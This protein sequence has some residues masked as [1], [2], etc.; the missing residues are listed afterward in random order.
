MIILY[1][2]MTA[3]TWIFFTLFFVEAGF[4]FDPIDTAHHSQLDIRGVKD[5][6]ASGVK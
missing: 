5:E 4:Y 2:N 1:N 3:K 6:L